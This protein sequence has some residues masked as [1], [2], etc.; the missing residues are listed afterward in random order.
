MIMESNIDILATSIK[1]SKS[2]IITKI[3][4]TDLVNTEN[5]WILTENNFYR[6]FNNYHILWFKF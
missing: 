2:A 3:T 6:C 5:I 1:T 4:T